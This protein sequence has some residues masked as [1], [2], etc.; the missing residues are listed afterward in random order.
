M[1]PLV[2]VGIAYS[3]IDPA[4]RRIRQFLRWTCVGLGGNSSLVMALAYTAS[5]VPDGNVHQ[6]KN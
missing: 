3:M 2:N 6:T 1:L 4:R 5:D